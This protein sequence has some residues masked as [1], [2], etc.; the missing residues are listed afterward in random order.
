MTAIEI[1]VLMVFVPPI[2]LF[3]FL[4]I[5]LAVAMEKADRSKR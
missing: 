4:F 3:S 2:L 5:Y 1:A